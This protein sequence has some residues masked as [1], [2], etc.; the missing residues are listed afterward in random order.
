ML[1]LGGNYVSILLIF[2]LNIT[3][4]SSVN[5]HHHTETHRHTYTQ[6]ADNL[7]SCVFMDEGVESEVQWPAGSQRPKYRER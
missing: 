3:P 7:I 4:T 5:Q 2:C 1:Q 6:T